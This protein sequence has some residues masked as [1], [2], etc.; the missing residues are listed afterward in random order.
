[1]SAAT[2]PLPLAAGAPAERSCVR[3]E[4]AER[5]VAVLVLDPPH[6]KLAV[7]DLPLMRDLA[8]AIEDLEGERTLRGL[9]IT[10]RAPTSFAAGADI[11][12][13]ETLGDAAVAERLARFGQDLFER[14]ARLRAFKVAA[15][16]GPVPGGAF[17]LS[18]ACD[19]IVL[20]DHPS[21]RIGLPET[22]LGILPAWGGCQRLPRRVGVPGALAA[23]L[24]GKLYGAREAWRAGL[25]DRLAA[26]ENLRRIAVEIA[27]GR[28]P[29]PRRERGVW[30]VLVD[31]N[32]L[33][34][35]VIARTARKA[36]LARTRGHYPAPERA[37]EL[38]VAAPRTPIERGFAREAKALGDLAVTPVCKSL[39][40]I[41]RGSEEAK[42]L[43]RLADGRDAP[44]VERAGVVGAGVMGGAIAGL[45]AERG[46]AVRLA[47]VS[48]P[49]IDA[50]A[51]EHRKRVERSLA[52][53]RIEAHEARAA[54]D[55]LET[56]TEIAGFQRC[57]LVVEAVAERIEVKREVFAKLAAQMPEDAILATNTSSLSVDAIASGLPHTE[58]VVGLH[59]FNPV[60]LM[61]LVEVVRG[62]RTS[63]LAVA[64]AARLAI[65]LGKTPIVV[66][67]VAGFLVN[68]L[69]GPYLDEALRLLEG[70]VAPDAIERAALDFGMPMGPLELLD[71]V[72]LDIAAH[73]ARS[74]HAAYGD[75]MAPSGLAARMV[76]Q[77]LLGKKT[78]AGFF[79]YER[80][81][82]E[83]RPRKGA[84][85]PAV[86]SLLSSA[87]SLPQN[88][89]T[90]APRLAEGEIAER[91][92]LAMANEAARCLDERVVESARV[93]DL[94]SV[95]GMGF[96]PFHGGL[97]RYV[98]ARGVADVAAALRRIAESP[99]VKA[100]GAAAAR[101]EPAG[102]LMRSVP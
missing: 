66:R 23:I 56:S 47:D 81:P 26:P 82:G 88:A 1:V 46:V 41:F 97:W 35:A 59:F 96:P 32:P 2:L 20:A 37:L 50:A 55:R 61:P 49:A 25:V 42:K 5:G 80:K 71:E 3:V 87:T 43:G 101:F 65:S 92:V 4:E 70:G 44:R 79:L 60:H 85:D 33:A 77:K 15:V 51:I 91:L 102:E 39:V 10:G 76:E 64:T 63:D 100:R 14:I 89:S 8:L 95:F 45:M 22:Q 40:A 6:R 57:Q 36:L 38:V 86:T 21:S 54:V 19:R 18:L 30:S 67:D 48:R 90:I 9:V 98:E 83:E 75:R 17:E 29:C 73:A 94:G 7:L 84:I 74:L 52:K 69:L 68:R 99:D 16:G 53:R 58:R 27:A 12:A 31:R 78:G 93:L 34:T 28:M 72:G 62:A 11:D 13:I 24:A